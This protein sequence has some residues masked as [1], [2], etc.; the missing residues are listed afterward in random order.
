[1]SDT[2]N[3]LPEYYICSDTLMEGICANYM[4][5]QAI[6][7]VQ[8]FQSILNFAQNINIQTNLYIIKGYHILI[9][10]IILH[11]FNIIHSDSMNTIY[12]RMYK[13]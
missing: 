4:N 8:N 11:F 12:N 9:P 7:S 3:K 2:R 10:L 5:F 13:E 6:L 1:M